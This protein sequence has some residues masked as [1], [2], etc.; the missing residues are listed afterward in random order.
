MG[1]GF[2]GSNYVGGAYLG[3]GF[4]PF[5]FSGDPSSNVRARDLDPPSGLS[6]DRL[7]D[8][9]TLLARLDR[10]NRARDVSGTMDGL[11]RFAQQAYEMVTGPAAREA[12][13]LSDEDPRLRDRYGRNRL[14]QT[15]L[16]ARRLVEAGVTFVTLSDGN[17]DHHGQIFSLCRAQVPP[18]DAAV[19]TLVEDIHDRGL[20][21]RVLVLVWGEFGR[22]PRITGNGRDHWPGSM[23]AL[24]AGG[25]LKMGQVVGSTTRKGESPAERPLR[26]EHVIRTVYHVLGIDPNHEFRNESGRPLPILNQADVI[27]ELI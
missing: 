23:F 18:L 13:D 7:D 14:G 10:I 2:L 6:L 4:N 12:L 11:D 3:P 20:A 25:G 9:K 27:R 22:T 16:L 8:R 5:T 26:P 17:W 1:N 24:L 19:A 15:C 21:D